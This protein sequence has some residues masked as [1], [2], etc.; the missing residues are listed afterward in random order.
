MSEN[1]LLR[2]FGRDRASAG[3]R[4]ALAYFAEKARALEE[5]K[6]ELERQRNAPKPVEVQRYFGLA[7]HWQAQQAAHRAAAEARWA[8]WHGFKG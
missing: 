6:L 4:D 3:S 8:T 2:P 5:Q 1:V 7:E